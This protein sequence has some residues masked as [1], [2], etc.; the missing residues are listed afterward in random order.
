MRR[1][2]E[3][4]F[5]FAGG[6]DRSDVLHLA[7]KLEDSSV[8]GDVGLGFHIVGSGLAA[9]SLESLEFRRW[10][11]LKIDLTFNR[12]RTQSRT[13]APRAPLLSEPRCM[14]LRRDAPSVP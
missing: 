1:Y 7:H 12:T 9:K 5:A 13:T 14:V 8:Q 11:L 4:R 10:A 6:R 3:P 2:G